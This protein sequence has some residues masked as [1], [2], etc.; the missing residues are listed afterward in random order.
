MVAQIFSQW[1][2]LKNNAGWSLENV[3]VIGLLVTFFVVVFLGVNRGEITRLWI[4]LAVFF[5][6]PASI[7]IAKI[8]K[9]EVLF[10]LVASTIVAQNILTLHRVGFII[11]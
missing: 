6:I 10:F 2:A 5:Q 3:Y 7:F 8:N 11:P 1:R 4:Y 9:G